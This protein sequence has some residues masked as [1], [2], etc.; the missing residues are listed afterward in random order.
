[1]ATCGVLK[2][3]EQASGSGMMGSRNR[4]ILVDFES[5]ICQRR[6]RVPWGAIRHLANLPGDEGGSQVLFYSSKSE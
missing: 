2:A 5:C 4:L 3:Q 1:M 6:H